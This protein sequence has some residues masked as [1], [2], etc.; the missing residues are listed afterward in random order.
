MK[1]GKIQQLLAL[2]MMSGVISDPKAMGLI[3]QPMFQL[4]PLSAVTFG[5]SPEFYPKRKKFKGYQREQHLG[6]RRSKYYFNKNR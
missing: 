5:G 4:P 6:R 2:A 1:K 3:S